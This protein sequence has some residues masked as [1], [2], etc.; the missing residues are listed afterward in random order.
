MQCIVSEKRGLFYHL[1]SCFL[2]CRKQSST[3]VPKNATVAKKNS[4]AAF[5]LAFFILQV[6]T[7]QV[8]L[9]SSSTETFCMLNYPEN[10]IQW[11]KGQGKNRNMPDARAQVGIISGEGRHFILKGSG[12]DQVQ[13]LDK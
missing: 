6:N 5:L 10:G 1:S 12:Y 9:A 8:V 13:K 3:Y 4:A 7:F 11:I 2:G